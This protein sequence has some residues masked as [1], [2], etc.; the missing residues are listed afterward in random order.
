MVI[1]M[2]AFTHRWNGQPSNVVALHSGV[3]DEPILMSAPMGH[4]RDIPMH[5]EADGDANDHAP[6]NPRPTAEPEKE[7]CD[8]NLMQHPSSLEENIEGVV[9]DSGA[10]IK[11]WRLVENESEIEIVK[12]VG[13]DRFAVPQEPMTVGLPLRPISNVVKPDGPKRTAHAD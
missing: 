12:A 13:K 7:Q 2:P 1:A 4:V 8:R 10:R 11:V 5:G 9:A 3:L 6:N